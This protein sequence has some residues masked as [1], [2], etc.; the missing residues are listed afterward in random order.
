MPTIEQLEPLYPISHQLTF[1]MA[2]PIFLVWIE[3]RTHNLYL[4][5]GYDYKIEFEV[6]PEGDLS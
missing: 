6:T 3:E 2:Q 1:E 5:A 4:L